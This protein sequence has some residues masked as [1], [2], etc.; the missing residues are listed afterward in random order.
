M[1]APIL[2]LVGCGGAHRGS[3]TETTAMRAVD[4]PAQIAAPR[5]LVP[6]AAGQLSASVQ[7]AAAAQFG[8]GAV[9]LGGLN[10]SDV[11]TAEIVTVTRAGARRVG[12]LPGALH[13]AAAATIGRLTY[14][15]GGGN[16]T[17]QL[18]GILM[19]DPRQGA[20]QQVGRL[21]AASSDSDAAVVG[22]TAYVVGGYTGT[23]WLDT[24]VAF[25]PGGHMRGSS[26]ISR[27]R[28]GMQP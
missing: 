8:G 9:L 10:A 5:R 3:T 25:T 15:F 6:T 16:G 24:I 22:R 20:A 18:D 11:S 2:L 28:S 26:R 21:P 12:R 13:D 17:A 1:V 4:P 27:T 19:V 14:L 23:R 7:D